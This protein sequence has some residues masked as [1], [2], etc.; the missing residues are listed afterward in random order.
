[1]TMSF[2]MG[3]FKEAGFPDGVVQCLHGTKEGI[4]GLS[5]S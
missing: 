5:Q 2:V 4:F 1:M 3:L